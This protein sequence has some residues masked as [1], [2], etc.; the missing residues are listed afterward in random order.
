VI[1]GSTQVSALKGCRNSEMMF[2]EERFPL[3]AIMN[4]LKTKTKNGTFLEQLPSN[5]EALS[6]NH[7]ACFIVVNLKKKKRKTGILV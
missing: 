2:H 6:S 1:E 7:R 3:S 5:L 4:N